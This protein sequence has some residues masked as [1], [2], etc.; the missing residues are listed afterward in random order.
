MNK[1]LAV[2]A[3]EYAA[4]VK[5]KAFIITVVLMPVLM[6]GAIF[7]QIALKDKRDIE[8]KKIVIVDKTEGQLLSERLKPLLEARNEKEIFNDEGKQIRPKFL[9]VDYDGGDKSDQDQQLE[10][11]DKVRGKEILAYVIIGEKVFESDLSVLSAFVGKDGMPNL[12][13]DVKPEFRVSYHSDAAYSAVL[14]WLRK[15]ITQVVQ[16][17]RFAQNSEVSKELIGKLLAPTPIVSKELAFVDD[18]TGEVVLAGKDTKG[19]KTATGVIL[20]FLMFMTVMVG[21]PNQLQVIVEEK[22]RRIAEVL[23]G[24]VSPF[25]LM[26]GKLLGATGITLTLSGIYLIGGWFSASY[27]DLGIPVQTLLTPSIVLWFLFFSVLGVLMFGSV[28]IAIGAACSELKDAQ[29]MMGPAMILMI[30]PMFVWFMVMKEPNGPVA[31]VLSFFPFATPMLMTMRIAI[32]PGP[33]SIWHPILG[34]AG[35][36]L[37]TVF[38]VWAAG[39][40]FRVGI[41]MQG[42]A[43]KFRQLIRW[44]FQS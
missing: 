37:A 33:P 43:P 7:M 9:L 29:N 11:A 16:Q 28:F 24:S 38:L 14:D 35:T 44:I 10:L 41:L 18:S 26:M 12:D 32:P 21:A 15:N 36:V 2:M 31:T 40:V 3:A 23:V 27:M 8:D 17:H 34:A 1:I 30:F 19:A 20:M 5:T 25:Q 13:P 6:G 39:R 22:M 42:Q 4:F